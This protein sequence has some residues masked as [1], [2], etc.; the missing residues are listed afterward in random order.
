MLPHDAATWGLWLAILALFLSVPMGIISILATPILQQWWAARSQA[1]LIMRRDKLL[2]EQR[3]LQEVPMID[4]GAGAV[5]FEFQ[6][7][8]DGL[9]GDVHLLI[10]GFGLV[11][12]CLAPIKDID[13][14][15]QGFGILFV[16]NLSSG[17][18]RSSRLM[19]RRRRISPE[20]RGK[21]ADEIARIEAKL[22]N[23]H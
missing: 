5:L 15:I 23:Y 3:E 4:A 8:T 22:A 9:T 10:G 20:L 21:L 7:L 18:L 17:I 11:L 16:M 12:W 2:R 6:M 19:R 14:A 13:F 1:S